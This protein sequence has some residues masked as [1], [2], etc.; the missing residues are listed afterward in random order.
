ME[1]GFRKSLQLFIANGCCEFEDDIRVDLP[2]VLD[3]KYDYANS[4]LPEFFARA[5][6]PSALAPSGVVTVKVYG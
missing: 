1:G 3:G 4:P 6:C 5:R 2:D